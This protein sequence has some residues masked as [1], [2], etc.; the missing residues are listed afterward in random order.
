MKRTPLRSKE[1]NQQLVQYKIELNKKDPV[2]LAETENEKIILVNKQPSFFYHNNLLIPTLKYLQQH[3]VLKKVAIDLGAIRFI[4]NGADVMRPGIKE[5]DL[6]IAKDE[7]IL[8][9]DDTHKKPI[10]VGI[11]LVSGS[12]MQALT[13]GKVIKTIHYVGDHLLKWSVD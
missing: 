9:I 12:E 3:N 8:I 13:T 10:A 1:V 4:I 6:T 11:A 5:I 2:E 7:P